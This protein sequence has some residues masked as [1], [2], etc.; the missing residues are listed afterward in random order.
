M[1][2]FDY[3]KPI[4]RNFNP[5]AYILQIGTNDLT[6]NKKQ[7]EICS[8]ISRLVKVRKKNK[9]KIVIST[10]VPREDACNTKVK[11]DN[12]LLKEFYEN[13][14]IDLILHDNINAKRHLNKTTPQ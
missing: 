3:L 4:Q 9:N 2:M 14:G 8:E 7:D 11:K 10:I 13:N 5:D 1:D 6:T 12:S